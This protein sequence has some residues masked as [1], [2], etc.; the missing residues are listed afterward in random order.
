[1]LTL[2]R[3]AGPAPGTGLVATTPPPEPPASTEQSPAPA[4]LAVGD[5]VPA[6]SVTRFHLA[7]RGPLVVATSL[8]RF[9]ADGRPL[10]VVSLPFEV[11]LDTTESTVDLPDGAT[12]VELPGIAVVSNGETLALVSDGGILSLR[13]ADGV[14][15]FSETPTDDEPLG[16]DDAH[17]RVTIGDERCEFEDARRGRLALACGD[18]LVL[19]RGGTRL[20]VLE[21]SGILVASNTLVPTGRS[22][23][24]HV[25]ARIESLRIEY[26]GRIYV[27]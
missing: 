25:D 6:A 21:R 10:W 13:L 20:Y 1:M 26:D 5:G 14:V 23:M 27:H 4:E 17:G 16:F 7:T 24:P 2:A 19:L 12:R 11:R 9:G 8:E 15:R 18:R 22:L 3:C